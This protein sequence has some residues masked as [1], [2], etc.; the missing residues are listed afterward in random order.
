MNENRKQARVI[1]NNISNW[2]YKLEGEK[3]DETMTFMTN[4]KESQEILKNLYDVR[5][6]TSVFNLELT[7]RKNLLDQGESTGNIYIKRDYK[8]IIQGNPWERKLLSEESSL[9]YY[10]L[11]YI[12]YAV[13]KFKGIP[14]GYD[15]R[16]NMLPPFTN[17]RFLANY[18]NL[19]FSAIF[20][21]LIYLLL[22]ILITLIFS[23]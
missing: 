7:G 6:E 15:R 2:I 12:A 17:L 21:I 4:L 8:A 10:L 18:Y 16:G 1:V 22:K 14:W 5:D 19:L 13:D 23:K 9:L 20:I 3:N 11:K